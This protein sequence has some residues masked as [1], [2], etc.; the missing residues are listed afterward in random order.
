MYARSGRPAAYLTTL[1]LAVST[2]MTLVLPAPEASAAP[3]AVTAEDC[4][5]APCTDEPVA[6]TSLAPS[7]AA[8]GTKAVVTLTGSGLKSELTLRIEN[9]SGDRIEATTLSVAADRRSLTAEFDLTGAPAGVWSLGVADG[10]YTGAVSQTGSFTVTQPGTAGLGLY[11]P[12]APTRLM[13]TRSG[14]GVPRAKVGPGG[15]V[16]LRVAG[17]AGL[18][19]EGMTSVVLNVT[20]TNATAASF[21][22]VYPDGAPRPSASNLNFT[23]GRTIPNV[24]V[25]PVVNGKV[26]FYNHSGSV[27]LLADVAGYYTVGDG[28]GLTYRPVRPIRLMDTR[29]GVGVPQGKVGAGQTVTMPVPEPGIRAVVL[30]VT[31][32]N[33]TASG[34]VSVYPYDTPRSS[35]SNLNFTAGQTIPNLVVVPVQHGKVTFY[36][37]AGSVDLVADVAGYFTVDGT[38]AA[39][40]PVAPRRLMDTRTGLGVRQGK[41]GAR[42]IVT[43]PVPAGVDA[44]V[45]N[46]TATAPT[47]SS[48]VQV[49]P[50][51]T[52]RD[53]ASNLNFTAG[54]T[55]PNAVV[56]PVVNGKV[57]FYNHAGSVDL[58]AD[59]F[60]YYRS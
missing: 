26:G 10:P 37:H 56:V 43:L 3:A 40:E 7:A 19:A 60:G 21:V 33:A 23:A 5:Q 13:D 8:S 58:L 15:T 16:T 42:E 12:V 30:N 18:P 6:Y 34:F 4:P 51:G 2:L 39:F 44:V 9:F 45:L 52:I 1:L 35:A 47:A 24:V 27:D 48:F 28:S 38:D 46:V 25:V 41:V 20:A 53:T 49:F 57:S 55:I 31:A 54:Q 17:A 32:T 36:N 14:L 50:D 59:V 11:Q 29:T 22:S